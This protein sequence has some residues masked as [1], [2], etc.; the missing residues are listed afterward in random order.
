MVSMAIMHLALLVDIQ[1]MEGSFQLGYKED[2]MV[3]H[4]SQ[5]NNLV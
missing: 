5:T 3:F 2:D 4:V 1:K